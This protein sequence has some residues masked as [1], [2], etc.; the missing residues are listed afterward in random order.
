MKNLNEKRTYIS[1]EEVLGRIALDDSPTTVCITNHII[2]MVT[3]EKHQGRNCCI[4]RLDKHYYVNLRTG[5]IKEFRKAEDRDKSVNMNPKFT[6][7]RQL[8]NKNFHGLFSEIHLI[9]TYDKEMKEREKAS[10]DFKAFW[11]RI[12]RFYSGLDYI[13]I[14][15][16][17]EKG[18]WHIHVL[19]KDSGNRKLFIPK[20]HL[21]ELWGHGF[22]YVLRIS[23]NDNIGAYFV[24]LLSEDREIKSKKTNRLQYYKK[25]YR[26]F[27]KSKGI[28]S[29]TYL[30]MPY[31][32]A[33]KLVKGLEPCFEENYG[34]YDVETGDEINVIYRKHYNMKRGGKYNAREEN[35]E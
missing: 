12:K 10:V 14:Y 29:P 11:K 9:L 33:M 26:V 2:E 27:S 30:K 3:R 21:K 20:K 8:I 28:E 6:A 1:R 19:V 17:T 15:E 25:G 16:P 24:A 35:V 18:V 7:L 22:I 23:D 13:V 34:I 4:R 31:S 32:E 5:E